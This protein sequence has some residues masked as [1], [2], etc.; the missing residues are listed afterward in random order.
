ML[1]VF[2]LRFNIHWN[3]LWLKIK[4]ARGLVDRPDEKVG[5][6]P[7]FTQEEEE[8]LTA[9][10]IT[11][12]SFGFPI[13]KFDLRCVMKAYLDQTG[14][15]VSAFKE[16]TKGGPKKIQAIPR[17]SLEVLTTYWKLTLLPLPWFQILATSRGSTVQVPEKAPSRGMTL[18]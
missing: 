5:R 8:R 6:Q 10:A 3:T 12:S 18:L 4:Q 17:Y 14:R 16:T 1:F 7:V 9:Q 15:K 2:T 11:M 13:T